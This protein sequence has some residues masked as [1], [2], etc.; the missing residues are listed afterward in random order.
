MRNWRSAVTAGATLA[1]VAGLCLT[2]TP[3]LGDPPSGVRPRHTDIVG[4]GA[5]VT[6]YVVDAFSTGYNKQHP[7]ATT[8]LYSFDSVGSTNIVEKRGC[9]T[10]TRPTGTG[11]GLTELQANLRPANDSTDYCVDF[12]RASSGRASNSSPSSLLYIPFAIDAVTW[13]ADTLTGSTNAPGSLTTQ[14]LAAIYSC[15]ASVLGTGKS[16]PVTWNEVGGTSTDA[17]IPVV[18][19]SVSGTRKFFL[20]E[21]GV[22]TLGQCVQGQDN[23]V[24]QSEGTNPIFTNPSTAPDIVFPYSVADWLAQAQNHHSP[25]TQGHLVLRSVNGVKPL[26][27]KV[28]AKTIAW[29]FP[30]LREI[31]NVVRNAAKHPNAA[32]VVPAYLRPIFGNG[33]AGSGWICSNATAIA[34]TKSFGFLPTNKCGVIE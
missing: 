32:E 6:Q 2:S 16:G 10:R 25:G 13:A 9:G 8:K 14:Q 26:T 18:P 22:S 12:A 7:K 1:A 27:G 4:V 11:N 33:S 5:D 29:S 28:G 21:I 24:T 15:D 20:Q 19:L 30:Y 23:T 17:V 34:Q 31:Y 3:A